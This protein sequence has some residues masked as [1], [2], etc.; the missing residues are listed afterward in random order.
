MH[1]EYGI[2]KWNKLICHYCTE[3]KITQI[4]VLIWESSLLKKWSCYLFSLSV[5][6]EQIRNLFST[7]IQ[8]ETA[9]QSA[10]EKKKGTIPS[11]L[12]KD[13][14]EGVFLSISVENWLEMSHRHERKLL[15]LLHG[16]CSLM[17]NAVTS[18]E[19]GILTNNSVWFLSLL[20]HVSSIFIII[21]F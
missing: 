18:L 10:C 9:I 13:F 2:N 1:D 4:R 15:I 14:S 7:A 12:Y 11:L 3:N 17:V 16:C 19:P 5:T 6:S 20:L 21:W 8:T